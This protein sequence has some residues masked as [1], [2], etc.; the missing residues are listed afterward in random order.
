VA[1]GLMSGEDDEYVILTDIQGIEDFLGDMDLKIAGT[2]QGVT[3]IQ[4]DQ[5]VHGLPFEVLARAFAQAREGRMHI[6]GEMNAVLTRPRAELSQYAPRIIKLHIDP[7]KIGAVIGPGGKMIRS[8]IDASGAEIDVEDDGSVYVT[9]ANAEGAKIAVQ[10]I[11]SLT[12]EPKV[13]DIFLGK[14]VRIMPYGAFVNILPNRD[15]MV[16]ISELDEGRVGR[17]EDVVQIGDEIN[18]MITQID[19]DGK[20]SLSRRAI[21]TGEQP[22]DAVA[23]KRNEGGSGGRGG[24]RDFGRDRGG[25]RRG[26]YDRDRRRPPRRSGDR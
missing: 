17:V 25:E 7:E 12:R 9:T 16:H 24:G 22:A 13:G 20:I 5:K 21:L 15:G 18:V 3:A 10:M 8:I 1:M 11:E 23:R 26:G 19:S 14:V 4:M 6:L 2:Q